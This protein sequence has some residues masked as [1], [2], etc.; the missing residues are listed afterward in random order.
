MAHLGVGPEFLPASA[1]VPPE[2]LLFVGGS[3]PHK[4]LE[5]VLAVLTSPDARRLPPLVVV[6]AA[7]DDP[8]LSEPGLH[9]RVRRAASPDDRTLVSL[10]QRALA[11]LVPS[12]NEG[13]GLPALEAMACGCPVLAARAGA[14]P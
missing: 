12:H 4:N 10:Y 11:L 13:F 5:L 6:G 14:L 1:Q 9:G 7:A 8:R 2:H 3:D